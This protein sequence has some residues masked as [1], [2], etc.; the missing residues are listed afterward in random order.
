[1][2]CEKMAT[3]PRMG[4]F[5]RKW[6][7]AALL[8]W[9]DSWQQLHCTE[10]TLCSLAGAWV[11]SA[12]KHHLSHGVLD[13]LRGS[14]TFVS[15]PNDRM[16]LSLYSC[17]INSRRNLWT[18]PWRALVF[19][20]FSTSTAGHLA[21]EPCLFCLFLCSFDLVFTVLRI[22]PGPHSC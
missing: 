14:G 9:R 17:L 15:V 5:T 8:G 21:P 3:V 10:R 11:W 2:A 19:L 1:M 12:L 18:P 13:V 7:R 16:L 4:S 22:K 20:D 6:E